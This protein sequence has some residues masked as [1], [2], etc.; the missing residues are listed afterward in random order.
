MLDLVLTWKNN[1]IYK[2]YDIK[3]VQ[4]LGH[5]CAAVLLPAFIQTR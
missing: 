1:N 3:Y 5:G 2:V 4:G